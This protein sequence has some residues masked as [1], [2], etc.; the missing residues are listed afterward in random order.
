M[1]QFYR[2]E[3]EKQNQPL[4][5][6]RI[7]EPEQTVLGMDFEN[8]TLLLPTPLRP[9]LRFDFD[10]SP[11]HQHQ[12]PNHNSFLPQTQLSGSF[13]SLKSFGVDHSAHPMIE[14]SVLWN[15]VIQCL[16]LES[17]KVTLKGIAHPDEM[18]PVEL[19]PP[20][21]SMTNSSLKSFSLASCGGYSIGWEL[22]S[23]WLGNNVTEL[24]LYEHKIPNGRYLLMKDPSDLT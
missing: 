1:V 10:S 23:P 13:S 5:R 11:I 2:N 8:L 15:F 17:L 7:A 19:K 24:N 16:N 22:T 6:R 18:D 4:M 9:P 12:N 3:R 14:G 21:E 20:K